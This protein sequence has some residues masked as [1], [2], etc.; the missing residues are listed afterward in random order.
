V[1]KATAVLLIEVEEGTDQLQAALAARGL[2][3]APYQR[4]LL[5]RL[6]A[7]E[8]YD[9][10]RD[11]VAALGLPLRRMEQ[12]RHRIEELFRADATVE[13]VPEPGPTGSGPTTGAARVR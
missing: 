6:T 1:T 10:V 12:R 11:S 3:P 9:A 8:V 4:G 2:G 13:A 7:D 5:V